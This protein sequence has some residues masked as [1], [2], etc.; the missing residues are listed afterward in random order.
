MAAKKK[1]TKKVR[2]KKIGRPT[3]FREEYCDMLIEHMKNL[4]SFESFGA[5]INTPRSTMYD[6]CKDHPTFSYAK[7]IAREYLQLGMEKVGR[8][9]MTG[10]I[11]GNVASWIFYTKNVT[12]WRDEPDS[13]IED[14][15]T[16]VE[17][18]DF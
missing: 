10:K 14:G 15:I 16:S 8:G 18:S 1:A 11:K 5:V 3:L 12:H 7:K 9:L 13:D 17:F 6:W 2:S 4:H